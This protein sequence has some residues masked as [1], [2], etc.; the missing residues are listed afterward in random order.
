MNP[1]VERYP[2]Y[3]GR[4]IEF[5]FTSFEAFYAE[6]GP[7][8][9]PKSNYSIDRIEVNGHYEPGNIRWTTAKTQRH[10]RRKKAA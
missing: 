3:G 5:R 9:V 6:V 10:N 2:D 1:N 7:K 4:G 8:P